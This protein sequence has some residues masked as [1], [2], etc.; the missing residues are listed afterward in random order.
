[1]CS[2]ST[3]PTTF[4]TDGGLTGIAGSYSGPEAEGRF[5]VLQGDGT[6]VR[7][8]AT[9]PADAMANDLDEVG[10]MV[11]TLRIAAP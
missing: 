3:T 4:T 10:Q 6:V 9:G 11:Q 5:A 1:M 2:C 8:V 7:V